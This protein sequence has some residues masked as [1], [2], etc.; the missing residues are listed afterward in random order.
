MSQRT[1]SVNATE[2]LDADTLSALDE[3]IRVAENGRRWTVE[4][5]FEIV[6]NRRKEWLKIREEN[7]GV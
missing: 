7:P 3:G 4:E 5:A 1:I 6:R 2:T